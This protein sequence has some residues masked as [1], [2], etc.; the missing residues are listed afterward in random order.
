MFA[1]TGLAVTE[2]VMGAVV[3]GGLYLVLTLAVL[4]GQKKLEAN[5]EAEYRR[6]KSAW[7][8]AIQIYRRLYYCFRDDI[9]FDPGTGATC[10]PSRL[11]E[12]LYS[13]S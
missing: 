11:K 12:Y 9:L 6:E 5:R 7:D 10:A 4:P 2:S 13:S 8:V 3:G 1:F